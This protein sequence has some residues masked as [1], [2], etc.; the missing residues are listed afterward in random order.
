MTDTHIDQLME[1]L[2]AY[3]AEK[4]DRQ[5]EVARSLGVTQQRLNDYLA[6]RV[7]LDAEKALTVVWLL[8]SNS[9]HSDWNGSY[10]I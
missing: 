3:C 2:R 6:G 8:Q 1:E 7:R 5:A 10:D 9:R 4:Y